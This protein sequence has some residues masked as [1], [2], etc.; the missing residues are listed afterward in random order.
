MLRE[1]PLTRLLAATAAAA[2]AATSAAPGPSLAALR[3]SAAGLAA[4]YDPLTG[5]Y[6]SAVQ[7]DS[8]AEPA[9]RLV[10][11]GASWPAGG[12]EGQYSGGWLKGID[13]G[14]SN[15]VPPGMLL[16]KMTVRPRCSFLSHP[17]RFACSFCWWK[18]ATT[19][20]TMVSQCRHICR[21]TGGPCTTVVKYRVSP[22]ASPS[23]TRA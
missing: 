23:R 18:G 4:S 5:A 3:G 15:E 9:H 2:D 6:M 21:Y 1:N 8:S 14:C 16:C 10:A 11:D 13:F 17:V 7:A 12:G 22:L 20:C 19:A